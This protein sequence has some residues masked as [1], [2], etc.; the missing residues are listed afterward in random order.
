M[1]IVPFVSAVIK[2]VFEQILKYFS[3]NELSSNYCTIRANSPFLEKLVE[4]LVGEIQ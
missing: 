4:R 2:K 1:R 3:L